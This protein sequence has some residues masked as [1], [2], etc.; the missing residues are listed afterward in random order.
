MVVSESDYAMR[1][2]PVPEVPDRLGECGAAH[3]GL[4]MK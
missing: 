1:A 2:R 4:G 3:A